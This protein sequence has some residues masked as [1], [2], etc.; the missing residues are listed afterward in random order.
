[1]SLT[2]AEIK[3]QIADLNTKLEKARKLLDD[4]DA[5]IAELAKKGVP[6]LEAKIKGLEEELSKL[7]ESPKK[8]ALE[9]KLDKTKNSVKAVKKTAEKKA[10]SKKHEEGV[11]T[12]TITVGGKK[13]TYTLD[14]CDKLFEAHMA[15][16]KA[17]KESSEKSES[18]SL[19]EKII[20]KQQVTIKQ[21]LSDK[22][23][24]KQLEE[25][26]SVT[27]KQI[28]RVEQALDKFLGEVEELLGKKISQTQ[29]AKLAKVFKDAVK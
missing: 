27:K 25:S 1:M 14:Q 13:K 19:S 23:V 3:A 16:K 2:A 21:I 26:P 28:A 5:D 18:R 17:N 6:K 24:R 15:K 7:D 29:K 10:K 8:D 9:D 12:V 20:D 11:E 4:K 22:S